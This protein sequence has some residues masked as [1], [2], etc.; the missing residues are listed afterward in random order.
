MS[1]ENQMGISRD[2]IDGHKKRIKANHERLTE[3][4]SAFKPPE[5]VTLI[6]VTK[7]QPIEVAIAASEL[8]F[9]D[10]GENYSNELVEK[11]RNWPKI[12]LRCDNAAEAKSDPTGS[13]FCGTPRWHFIGQL[14]SNKVRQL[15]PYVALWQ[16]VDRVRLLREIAKRVES[17]QVLLQVNLSE[18]ETKGGC[19]RTDLDVLVETAKELGLEVCGLMGV[20]VAGDDKQTETGFAWL[21]EKTD[22]LGLVHCSMGMSGD[23]ELALK[24]GST[25]LRVGSALLGQRDY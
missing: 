9:I 5:S 3:R 1:M 11:A 12:E 8:G 2:I 17:A 25:M 13:N 24:H 23:L 20:G 22:E 16:S 15:A 7:A 19:R 14:Q 10:L 6:A 21:R 4:I 18:N